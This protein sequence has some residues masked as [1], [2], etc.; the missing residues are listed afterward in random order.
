M[1]TTRGD[2]TLRYALFIFETFNAELAAPHDR[3]CLTL[4]ISCS[5]LRTPTPM[6]RAI[7]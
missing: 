2:A 7:A 1:Q 6:P 4:V 5:S 3:L